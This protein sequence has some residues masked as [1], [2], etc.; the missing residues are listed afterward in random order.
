MLASI[1]PIL[2]EVRRV[3][4]VVDRPW[5][6]AGSAFS[7]SRRPGGIQR[8]EAELEAALFRDA[9]EAVALCAGAAGGIAPA[10]G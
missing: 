5:A 6:A 10:A 2:V 1:R 7:L 8:V 4:L 9:G 3:H